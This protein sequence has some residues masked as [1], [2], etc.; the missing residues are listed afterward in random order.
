MWLGVIFGGAV[1][2]LT[3]FIIHWIYK[4]R[5]PRGSS[6][7]GVLPPGSMGWPLIGETLHL[8][9]PSKSL[10][11]HPFIKKRIQR[12]GS[13]F[14]TSLAGRPVIISTDAE[15][16]H[17]LFL[18]EGR[19]VEMWYLDTFAKL[20]NLDGDSKPTA[21]GAV[22]R[23][24]RSIVLNH[25]GP[26]TL[27]EKLLPRIEQMID[28]T[29]GIWSLQESV[30][31]KE[32][33]ATLVFDC[34]AKQM[35]GYDP[36]KSSDKLC[37]KFTSI[38]QGLMSFPLNIPGTAFHKCLKEQKKIIKMIR[39]K[40]REKRDSP[41]QAFEGDLLD[42]AVKEMSTEKF[43]TEDFIVHFIFGALFAS[44]ESISS[45]ITL[46]FKL[47]SENPSVVN[48]LRVE[49]D[50]IIKKREN[51]N[52]SLTWDDYKS[53]PFTLQVINETL[54]LANVSPGLLRRAMK[55]IEVNGYT[56]PAG[57]TIMVA[58]SAQQL[59]PK[60]YQDPLA[61]NPYRWK[62]LD[63]SVISKNF[64]PFGGGMRQCAGAEFTRAFMATFFHVLVTKYR[65]TKIKGG[66]NFGRTPFLD[67]GD[68]IHIKISEKV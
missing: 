36:Q 58:T 62:E 30:P 54:R 8:L 3:I 40:L 29:L 19:S 33:V 16:N 64:M 9:I 11:L 26:D 41:D 39:N 44:F 59:N 2:V 22:H 52:S 43:L 65:W 23:Y 60:T 5:N 47:L 4:W 66:D 38:L 68:G 20:F 13:L 46:A 32:A 6:N 27:R 12:Y 15:V 50:A 31:V 57:W 17:Y 18:Q 14:R 48:E 42:Q 34:T 10:D 21:F 35:I 63:S 51:P 7:G 55:D 49:H 61:F 67:F 1:A 24:V 45:A 53:M 56:I 25:F 28:S 37:E